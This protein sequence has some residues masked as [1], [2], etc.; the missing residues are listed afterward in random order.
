[1]PC[2]SN[3]LNLLYYHLPAVE[4]DK[5]KSQDIPA[6]D[7]VKNPDSLDRGA[8]FLFVFKYKKHHHKPTFN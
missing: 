8:D 5:V 6:A 4:V 3:H 7:K 1:M 2:S